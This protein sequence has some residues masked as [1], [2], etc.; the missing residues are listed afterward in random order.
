MTTLDSEP[1]TVVVPLREEPPGVFRVGESR[2]LLELVLRVF[3]A[4]ATPEAIVQSYDTLH[5]ADVY[6]VISR[7]L[8]APPR[9]KTTCANATRRPRRPGASWRSSRGPGDG[10]ESP[11]SPHGRGELPAARRPSATPADTDAFGVHATIRVS[12]PRSRPAQSSGYAAPPIRSDHPPE[13]LPPPGIVSNVA[14]HNVKGRPGREKAIT[15]A[16]RVVRPGG[17][18]L[19]ADLWAT[20]PYHTQLAQL[21]MIRLGRRGLGWRLWWSGPWLPTRLVTATKPPR[22]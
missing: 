15:E 12:A 1:L 6:A 3:Q 7:Y 14:L 21:G 18:L 9:S 10:N 11:W 5:L 16:V 20:R 22:P 13:G 2:V 4:G 17:R 8:A 19:I